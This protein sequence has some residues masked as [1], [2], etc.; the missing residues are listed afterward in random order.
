MAARPGDAKGP[1]EKRLRVP[2]AP[3]PAGVERVSGDPA[4]YVSRVHRL[5][6]GD[7]FTAFDPE[8]GLE[9][10]A[11]VLSVDK[12]GLECRFEAPRAASALVRSGVTLVVAMT[13]GSKIDDVIRA[14]T[15]LGVSRL[16]VAESERSMIGL[17]REPDKR[18]GRFRAIAIDAARQSGRGDLPLIEGPLSLDRVLETL[19]ESAAHK[20]CL[21]P[22]ATL[23][24]GRAL[25]ARD[26][27]ELVVLVG[28][29]GGFSAS[30]LEQAERSGFVLA[31]FGELVLRAELAAVAALGAVLAQSEMQNPEM[32]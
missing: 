13:K 27:R 19:A 26:A 23:P 9:A 11:V 28:P 5:V 15:A 22:D 12:T 17:G 14:G 10:D 8:A 29:E 32:Q 25:D 16:V 30:E 21:T 6:A 1:R 7:G 20:I 31:R 3:L 4:H 2:L 18:T 24:F